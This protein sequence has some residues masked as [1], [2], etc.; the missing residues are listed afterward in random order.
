[1]GQKSLQ[2]LYIYVRKITINYELR[3]LQHILTE[4]IKNKPNCTKN[5]QTF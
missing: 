4:N 2:N 1:M 5:K 3:Y